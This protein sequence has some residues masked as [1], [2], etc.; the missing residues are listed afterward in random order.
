[1]LIDLR[2]TNGLHLG[3]INWIVEPM[4]AQSFWIGFIVG[5]SSAALLL[6]VRLRWMHQRPEVQLNFSRNLFKSQ[7]SLAFDRTEPQSGILLY[8]P[9]Q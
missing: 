8:K 1:M 4:G 5:L 7:Q 3:R 2:F 6:G 9:T